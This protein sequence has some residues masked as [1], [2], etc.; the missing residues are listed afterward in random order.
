MQ[1]STSFS[2]IFAL[3]ILAFSGANAQVEGD[4]ATKG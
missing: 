1:R 4:A 3:S 2:T